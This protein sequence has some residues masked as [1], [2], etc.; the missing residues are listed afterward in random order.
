M[1]KSKSAYLKLLPL[2]EFKNK[3]FRGMLNFK[4]IQ[5]NCDCIIGF[6]FE[7]INDL[8][9][10][11]VFRYHHSKLFFEMLSNSG[12]WEKCFL[13]E[14]IELTKDYKTAKAIVRR[15]FCGF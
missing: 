10:I 13:I 12:M 1:S 5:D 8:G 9:C 6:S 7:L 11:N 4:F 14:D 3:M 2:M 15:L